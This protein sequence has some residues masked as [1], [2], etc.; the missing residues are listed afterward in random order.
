MLSKIISVI[1]LFYLNAGIACEHL[2][3]V[4]SSSVYPFI[5]LAAEKYAR[6]NNCA[7]IVESTGTG[8]GISLFCTAKSSA[9]D[10]VMTSR[11]FTK[12]ELKLCALHNI[13][14]IKKIELGLDG[15]VLVNSLKGPIYKLSLQEL[16]N[17]LD[18]G[19]SKPLLWREINKRL[20]HRKI[21]IYGPAAGSGTRADFEE[22][23]MQNQA[24]RED[25]AFVAMG[26]NINL[27]I[28]KL[29]T[30]TQALGIISYNFLEYNMDKIQG[31]L[32]NNIAPTYENIANGTYPLSRS[33]YIYVNQDLL[34]KSITLQNFI[35]YIIKGKT[36]YMQTYGLIPN[37]S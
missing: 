12:S 32:I 13:E 1:F 20:P 14:N 4:G 15:I 35:Q 29:T 17:A 24:I 2:R 6:N 19:G 37:N 34:D 5:A 36:S 22:L 21:M 10:I 23:V 18:K 33:L 26:N 11:L 7:P 16:F 31:A 30:N 8:A 27:I 28:Q 3:I 9:P 25:G